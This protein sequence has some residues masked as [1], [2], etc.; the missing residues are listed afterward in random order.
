[1]EGEPGTVFDDEVVVE[2]VRFVAEDTGFG[3]VEADRDGD[4]IV[5][6]GLIG[7]LER[8]ERVG[9]RGVW[10]DDTRFGMQVKVEQAEPRGPTGT[11]GLILYLERV[12][13]IGP[14]RAA[15]LFQAF[16]DDVLHAVDR[17]PRAAFKPVGLSA[18]QA[19]EAAPSWDG[20]RSTRALHLL[21][22]PH[23]LAW[24]VARLDKQYGPSAHRVVRERP[25]ELTSV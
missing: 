7:H 12:K 10:Q 8:G 21:L 17:D 19:A 24:L 9:V 2:R 4:E 13:G 5:L 16:G 25:Y 22:A 14:T 6:V 3:V 20:L 1:M 11:K 15:R 23:G 18:R